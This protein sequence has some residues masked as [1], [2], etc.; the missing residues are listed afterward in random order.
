MFTQAR[1]FQ[2]YFITV[3]LLVLA[4]CSSGG[5]SGG[6]VQGPATTTITGTVKSPA[7]IVVLFEKQNPASILASLFV[8]DLQAAITGLVPVTNATVE[9]IRINND[10]TQN[11]PVITSTTTD[12]ATG[13]YNLAF[14]GTLTAD[15]VVQVTATDVSGTPM[16]ALVTA[17]IT[18]INPVTEYVLRQI[19]ASIMDHNNLTLSTV[20]AESVA[21]LVTFIE[22]LNITF[23][24]TMDVDATATAIGAEAGANDIAALLDSSLYLLN[25]DDISA[26][27]VMTS[28]AC[29]DGSEGGWRYTFN[30]TG[31]TLTGSDTFQPNG[32]GNCSTGTEETIALTHAEVQAT[33]DIPFNCGNDNMCTYADLNKVITGMDNDGRAFTSTYT[34]VPYSDTVTY[35]K[36]ATPSAGGS[37]TT[38]TEVLT[39]LTCNTIGSPYS[40][41]DFLA[42]VDKCG[43]L[44]QLTES[45]VDGNTVT[46]G[47]STLLFYTGGTGVQYQGNGLPT[48][49][50]DWTIDSGRLNI[51]VYNT[52]RT[53]FNS[54]N[55]IAVY[56]GNPAI[57]QLIVKIYNEDSDP[58]QGDLIFDS[59]KDGSI[60]GDTFMVMPGLN[61]PINTIFAGMWSTTCTDNGNDTYSL[62]T[63]DINSGNGVTIT[64]NDYTDS[65]CTAM[66]A[67]TTL[68]GRL[69]VGDDIFLADETTGK[70]VDLLIKSIDGTPGNDAAYTLFQLDPADSNI[71]RTADF[72]SNATTRDAIND[73]TAGAALTFNRQQN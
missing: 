11:G 40:H 58:V 9:L 45:N 62:V 8:P 72:T 52:D 5:D 68:D 64:Y 49:D 36:V 35:V 41:K 29:T 13:E 57:G 73:L 55:Q 26:T 48:L 53:A 30:N 14:A 21:E 19:L 43:A 24:D 65:I 12:A 15:L 1:C 28:S 31:L 67:T 54:S 10:G 18:D 60:G 34:H 50:F 42:V 44:R 59:H 25:L 46:S 22:A 38:Y 17:E 23:T 6:T 71:L 61:P 69:T 66:N 7:S 27:S 51:D 32:V 37:S 39:L 3:L 20:T 56:G 63:M 4:G 2:F 33:A 16:R 70:K 47:S